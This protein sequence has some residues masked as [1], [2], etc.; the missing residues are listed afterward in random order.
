MFGFLNRRR[1]ECR[2]EQAA[3]GLPKPPAKKPRGIEV[4]IRIDAAIA[5][6]A[7]KDTAGYH[8]ISVDPATMSDARKRKLIQIRKVYAHNERE[9]GSSDI[10]IDYEKFPE[11]ARDIVD[12]P[13]EEAL[14]AL[15]DH[16]IARDA[17]RA[18][19]R[20]AREEWL[21]RMRESRVDLRDAP[22]AR[23]GMMEE[24]IASAALASR[25][26]DY[27]PDGDDDADVDD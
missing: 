27:E 12:E 16:L 5:L 26:V 24:A 25:D 8:I 4:V 19:A 2:A 3:F 1:P 10:W 6:M 22:A 14:F 7:G 18:A 9:G 11:D 23:P 21:Q 13:T 15:L 20:S 17:G